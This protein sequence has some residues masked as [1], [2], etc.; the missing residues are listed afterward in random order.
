MIVNLYPVSLF[1]EKLHSD[2][3]FGA[4]CY[5]ISEMGGDV[6]ELISAYRRGKA[7][8]ILSSAF[9]FIHDNSGI[10]YFLPVPI[11]RPAEILSGED[12][13]CDALGNLKLLKKIRYIRSQ[14]FNMIIRGASLDE[15]MSHGEFKVVGEMMVPQEMD[16]VFEII[17]V[18]MARNAIDRLSCQSTSM[19]YTKGSRFVNMGLFFLIDFMDD[20]YKEIVLSA[21]RFLE[22]RGIGGDI[23]SGYGQFRLELKDD[24]ELIDVVDDGTHFMTLSLYHPSSD[25]EIAQAKR[26]ELVWR[27]GMGAGGHK[28]GV[29]MFG[30]G[31][32]FN[33]GGGDL[34]GSVEDIAHNAVEYGFAYPVKMSGVVE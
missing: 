34:L 15:L 18:D 1:P 8:F 5:A 27:K 32:V 26:Y 24:D 12:I 3:I 11:E 28:K 31:S 22:D 14:E 13:S 10:T 21:L 9:P 16:G 30:E 29:G 2:T 33:Y 23:S 25:D 6:D 20:G 4:I 19:F 7:P 17:T